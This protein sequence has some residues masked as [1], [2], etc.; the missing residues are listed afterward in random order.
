VDAAH[1]IASLAEQLVRLLAGHARLF[2]RLG[3]DPA[4]DRMLFSAF[5]RRA[6][7]QRRANPAAHPAI[8]DPYPEIARLRLCKDADEVACLERAAAVTAAGHRAAMRAA[9]PGRYE[10]EVQAEL[11]AAFRRG[12]AMREGYPSIVA[13]GPNACIL[14]YRENDRRMR[15]GELLLLDAG[16]EVDMYTADVTRTLPVGGTFSE[17]QRKVY[18]LVLRAQKAA[19]AAVAPGAP[20]NAPHRAAVR[21]LTQGLVDLGVLPRRPAATLI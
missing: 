17:A 4:L 9:R 6:E 3:V 14:H 18:A 15:R 21:V 12:G 11:E 8:L 13:S 5:A 16:A 10:Y 20:W 1:P 2:H 7:K 19:I